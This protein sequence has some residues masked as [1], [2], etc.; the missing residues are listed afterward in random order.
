MRL[1][2]YIRRSLGYYWRSHLAV[3][4][5]V[6]T[7][8]GTLTGALLVGDS[9]RASLRAEALAGLGKVDYA[10]TATTF[11][12]Q[13]MTEGLVGKA[14]SGVEVIK[15][16]PAIRLRG[17]ISHAQTGAR[18]NRV[19][20]LGVT[21]DIW[22]LVGSNN[23]DPP[24]LPQ[25]RAVLLSRRLAEQLGARVGGDVL[26][27]LGTVSPISTE[28]LLG[29]RDDT[30]LTLRVTVQGIVSEAQGGDFTLEPR[31]TAPYNAWV[32]LSVLQRALDRPDR[33]N[34]VLV[35]TR[36]QLSPT[37]VV[38]E[39][40]NRLRKHLQLSDLG[41]SL[42]D[43]QDRGYLAFES[44]AVLLDPAVERA[45]LATAEAVGVTAAPVLT[46]L[47][48]SIAAVPA[49]VASAGDGD[50]GR[51]GK[52]VLTGAR[53]I[54][55]STVAA[56]DPTAIGLSGL[57]LVDGSP[58]AR[59]EAGD[60]LLNE[61][62]AGDLGVEVGDRIALDYYVNEPMGRLE[63]RRS[64]FR[65][66]GV[67]RMDRLAADA[68]F[69]PSYPGITDTANLGE[70]D[71]PFPIDLER[72]RDRDEDY[73]DKYNA[74]PKAFICLSDGRTLWA[75]GRERLGR[76]TSIRFAIPRARGSSE[77]AEAL[78]SELCRRLDPAE[79]GVT[80]D[81]VRD[82]ALKAGAGSTDFGVLFLSFSFFLIASAAMLVALLF[83]L[84]AERRAPDS[85]L[86]LATG[87]SPQTVGRLLVAEG[88]VV[89]A[90]GAVLGLGAAVG[91]A[92]L[93]LA[94]LKSWW[95]GAVNA[96]FLQLHVSIPSLAIGL[97]AGVIIAVFSIAW[98]V[99][100]LVRRTPYALLMRATAS[101]QPVVHR[102]QSRTN[103]VIGVVISVAAVGLIG[104]AAT[105]EVVSPVAGFFGGG[106]ALV[107]SALCFF[108]VWLSRGSRTLFVRPGYGAVLWLGVRNAP[109][110][111]GRSVLVSGLIA[112]ASFVIAAIGA[113]H[114][115][116]DTDATS[117]YSSTGGFAL[118]AESAIPLPQDLNTPE[119]R[120][121]LG[122]TGADE[123]ISR[124]VRFMPFRLRPGDEAGC[125]GLYRPTDPR[126]IGAT[127]EMITRGGFSFVASLARTD[128]EKRNPWTLLNRSFADGA[129]P[130]IGEENAVKWQLHLGL[131]EDL[132][133][134]NDAGEDTRLR[135][136]ALLARS[137][138]QD[139]LI[140]SETAFVR[141][142]PSI[143][144]YGFVLVE[145]PDS[146][147]PQLARVL[148]EELGAFA[149][150]VTT[151]SQRLQDYSTV[152]NTYLRTFQTLGGF[153]LA[154]GTVGLA[155]VLLRN[156]VER[157]SELAL[158]TALGFSRSA[159][160][161]MVLA[162]NTV[163]VVAGLLM[164]VL[165][166]M[167]AI[168]PQLMGRSEH[169]PWLSL[170]ITFLAVFATG[171]GAG[172]LACGW[173]LRGPL[174]PALRSE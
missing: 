25:G 162:E 116:P 107:A 144:G 163:L 66:R 7:A 118:V 153:G 70:W 119:G 26:L 164:G 133:I 14:S 55:Y 112:S 105:T 150:D 51:P 174:L 109:R 106:A 95:A 15:A 127:N 33:V 99:R 13:R 136:V 159:V 65:L 68:G 39:L 108:R 43:D 47:A 22:E 41:L 137:P 44:E 157:R 34:T 10:V 84:G 168:S 69:A 73:W 155:V 48:N 167:V 110:N 142:F 92:W 103:A 129:V 147:A 1:T 30:Y 97:V 130:V 60:I 12:N 121:D 165:P 45:A 21:D 149:L 90:F 80:V 161:R 104:L 171:I 17:G 113:M 115:E 160:R 151:T 125:R 19:G 28:T 120:E 6:L 169:V 4:L 154:L 9:M 29:R 37:D 20:I 81:A 64:V 24:V 101:D 72:V 18:V 46:Y 173:A 96:P 114:V 111:P 67:V 75:E 91:Y 54:P 62:A 58:A 56:L 86:L 31:R 79:L 59:L 148:E 132:V 100:R 77:Y 166:A 49:D 57:T 131:G 50:F 16:C 88:A 27:R 93:M 123:I 94:G 87:F 5:G 40:Q 52:P 170:A 23:G 11:F 135:F 42:R 172:S 71:P 124:G 78:Q 74:A 38:A 76:A 138:L 122:L 145:A 36:T 3:A 82:R 158:M 156:L 146:T 83:G 141:E 2:T 35:K 143:N 102:G 152:Q 134:T 128:E 126:I 98:S 140:I 117:R 63:S 53:S 139:E 85:G 8:T 89:A 32:P 61:W